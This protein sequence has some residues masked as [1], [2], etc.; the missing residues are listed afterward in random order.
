[1]RMSSYSVYECKPCEMY[2]DA[3]HLLI[4]SLKIQCPDCGKIMGHSLQV[5]MAT[6]KENGW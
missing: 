3:K 4:L 6:F 1:M 2:I 5:D